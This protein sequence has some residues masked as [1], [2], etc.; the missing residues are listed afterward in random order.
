MFCFQC[1]EAARSEGCTV[2]GVCGKSASTAALQD[3]LLHGARGLACYSAALNA[4]AISPPEE[5]DAWLRLALFTT[6]TNA[7]F[8]D[9]AIEAQIKRG[10]AWRLS[11]QQLCAEAGLVV[12]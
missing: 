8:D 4:N 9:D 11:L 7:N 2:Q 6:I 3:A 5:S 10:F 1:Q 12:P